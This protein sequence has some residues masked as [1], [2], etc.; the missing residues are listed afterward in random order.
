MNKFETINKEI[1]DKLSNL[2]YK[3]GDLYDTG[4]EIGIIIAKYF[5]EELGYDS[6]FKLIVEIAKNILLRKIAKEKAIVLS[7]EIV[8]TAIEKAEDKRIIVLDTY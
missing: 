6:Q 8:D 7:K 4:N 1:S 3:N 5:D 2:K